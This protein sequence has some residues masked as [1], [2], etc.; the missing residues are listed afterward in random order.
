MSSD[1]AE[2]EAITQQ[3]FLRAWESLKRT[4]NVQVF[5]PWLIRIAVNAARDV[6]RKSRPFDF[7]D[8]PGEEIQGWADP[9]QGPEEV[10]EEGE[11]L[12][13]LAEA[14][15]ALPHAYREVIAL[16]YDAEMSYEQMAEVLGLPLN[17]VRTR[18]HRAK[19]R[20]RGALEDVR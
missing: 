7:A 18:L 3:A 16:C 17:T 20:L 8:L 10:V 4:K 19:G 15:D 14:V 6:L 2:A 5:L 12:E 11:V 9:G 1:R 13:R